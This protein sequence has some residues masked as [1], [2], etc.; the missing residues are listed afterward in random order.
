MPVFEEKNGVLCAE[1]VPLPDIAQDIGTPCYVYSQQHIAEQYKTLAD[2][3]HAHVPSSTP[4]K[5][6]YA[7]KANSNIAILKH[8]HNLGSDLE[9]VSVGELKRGLAAGFDPKQIVAT[10]VGK[11]EE[12]I[13]TYIEQ[14]IYQFN[15]ESEPEL[16]AINRIAESMG[17]YVDAVLRINPDVI[18]GGHHKTSTGR[19]RDKFGIGIERTYTLFDNK[20]THPHVRL[21]GISMHIGSQVFQ[22]EKFEEAFAKIPEVVE[23]IRARGHTVSRLD[24]GGGF[25]IIYKD[26]KFLDLEHYAKWVQDKIVPLDTEI[27]IEPGRFFVGN[28]CV[29]LTK[30]LYIKKTENKDFLVLDTAMNDLLRPTL[31]DAWH[32]ISPV[33][34]R[35]NPKQHYDIVGPICETGDTFAEERELP[36]MQA[37]DLAVIES[38]GAY[39]T[40]MASNY[41]TRPLAAEILVN[42]SEYTV[43]RQRQ[44]FEDMIKNEVIPE[45]LESACSEKKRA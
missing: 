39:A 24:I 27:I 1:N 29:L 28:S 35:D 5:I 31:Y 12:E 3:M 37:G 16:Y 32:T 13:T 4:L 9:I 19:K 25:P 40:S 43:I 18:G 30:V 22:V 44:T 41:N 2:T 6:C 11:T 26:E 45:W 36:K 33:R 38:A 15:I 20:D 10:G 7:C 42:D 14:G 23:E 8:L 21:L 34:N 17:Q